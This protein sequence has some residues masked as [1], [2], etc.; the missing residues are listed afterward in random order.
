MFANQNVI[1]ID[2]SSL[3]RHAREDEVVVLEGVDDIDD[4]V[5]LNFEEEE[6]HVLQ[7]VCQTHVTSE[8]APRKCDRVPECPHHCIGRVLASSRDVEVFGSEGSSLSKIFHKV[9]L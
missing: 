4:S 2:L 9:V 7:T 6:T 3:S 1:R 8:S 5:I